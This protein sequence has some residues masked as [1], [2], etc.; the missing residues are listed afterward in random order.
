MGSSRVYKPYLVR[1]GQGEPM[2]NQSFDYALAAPQSE[3]A[4][5]MLK[6]PYNKDKTDVEYALRGMRQPLGVSCLHLS[7]V[8][9]AELES[10]LPT[11]EHLEAILEK[12]S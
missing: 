2:L 10:T 9:P 4:Q 11:V 1:I 8:L 12:D 3:L 5:Q 7:D 6:D